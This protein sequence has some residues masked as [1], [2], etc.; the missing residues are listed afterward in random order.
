ML[1]SVLVFKHILSRLSVLF[2]YMHTLKCVM[3]YTLLHQYT[4]Y[5]LSPSFTFACKDRE[6]PKS[7]DTHVH[8]L[9]LKTI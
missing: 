2:L 8:T 3:S 1:D 5:L 4:D 6:I 7:R 9:R